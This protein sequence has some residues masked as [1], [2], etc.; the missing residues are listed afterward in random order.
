M[1]EKLKIRRA[2]AGDYHAVMDLI[3]RVFRP[4]E[5]QYFETNYPHLYRRVET[6]TGGAVLAYHDGKL[7][8]HVG[9]YPLSF[10]VGKTVLRV[11]GIGAVATDAP[12][13]GQGVMSAM[14]PAAIE[15][16]TEADYDISILWGDRRRYRRYGWEVAGRGLRWQFD[17]QLAQQDG[18]A[19]LPLRPVHLPDDLDALT[20]S[21]NARPL[22]TARTAENLSRL[23][24]R[25]QWY[26]FVAP[27]QP[28]TQVWYQL[29]DGGREVRVH[30][31]CGRAGEALGA[32]LWLRQNVC[33]AE[34]KVMVYSP[35]SQ[36]ASTTLA[37]RYGRIVEP[38]TLGLVRLVNPAALAEKLAPV[39]GPCAA[40]LAKVDLSDADA[41]PR[42]VQLLFDAPLKPALPESLAGLAAALPLPWW[43]EDPSRV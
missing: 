11:G 36:D 40:A 28:M 22:G 17:D 12:C 8:G 27:T 3:N 33:Q 9:I 37:E 2:E 13:R 10:R 20:E 16:M 5:P 1:S 42:L 41:G 29:N 14:L 7:V 23:L 38:Y 6:A 18:V 34:G 25:P 26:K 15:W 35:A 19:P 30:V 4:A 31:L 32:L 43:I 24:E 21:W 39:L